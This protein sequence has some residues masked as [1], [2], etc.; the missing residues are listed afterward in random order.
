MGALFGRAGT[1]FAL[2]TALA[3][4][5]GCQ[6]SGPSGAL[7]SVAP[8]A[9]ASTPAAPPSVG[10]GVQIALFMDAGMGGAADDY[11]DGALLA[12]KALGGG[13]LALTVHD[14]RGKPSDAAAQVKGQLAADTRFL[15]SSPSLGKAF[16]G[17][18]ANPAVVLLGSEPQPGSVAIVSDE[19]DAALEAATYAAGQGQSKIMVVATR[20]LSKAQEQRLRAGMTKG[21]AQLLGI[22]TDPG[23][24]AGQK[25]LE[26]LGE[27][28]A[29]LLLGA[30]AP[31]VVAPALRQRGGLGAQV[32]FLGS[33]AW[34]SGSYG[35]PALEGSLLALI[36][37]TSLKRISKRFEQAYGRPLS[38][39]AA[40]GF[41]AVA[42]AAGLARTKGRQAISADALRGSAGFAGATGVFR[43]GPDGRVERRLAIYRLKGGKPTLQRSA[44]AGF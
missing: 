26:K 14:L 34:P 31:S 3:V 22:V 35:E 43:F 33:H 28:Q 36:D 38:L 15:I 6:S 20:P 7:E 16:K 12:A 19:I 37:Q 18:A 2:L 17:V 44:P 4:L 29:V 5:S 32:P 9:D 21:G 23:S 27:A 40:Y 39:E 1:V 10:Q 42:V 11:R 13:T 30:E 25:S 8:P 41:D 24:S